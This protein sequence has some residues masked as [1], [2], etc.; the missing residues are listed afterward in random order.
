MTKEYDRKMKLK[1][2]SEKLFRDKC[3]DNHFTYLYIDQSQMKFSS[4]LWKDMA[5]KRPDYILSVPHIGSIFVDVKAKEERLFYK[6]V[7]V[8]YL[9]K[10][11][12]KAF[13]IDLEEVE[14]FKKLQNETSMKV[15]FAIMPHQEETVAN[16]IFFFPVDK[17]DKFIPIQHYDDPL[18]NYVQIPETCFSD[19][20]K[21]AYNKCAKC[22]EKY[23]E[24]TKEYISIWEKQH[25][26]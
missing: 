11:P 5:S 26:K 8:N 24:K 6:D 19:C 23:C 10:Q 21:L 15:W 17:A 13:R 7:F 22:Q 3:D 4:T 18:W 14:K 12:P 20:G 16:E 25:R 1:E 2:Q 9:N